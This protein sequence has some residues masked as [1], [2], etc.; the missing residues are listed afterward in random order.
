MV[1]MRCGAIQ[2]CCDTGQTS[3][4]GTRQALGEN[5]EAQCHHVTDP[6]SGRTV[7]FETSRH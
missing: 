6:R 1:G 5:I 4:Y 7:I 3:Y 2:V